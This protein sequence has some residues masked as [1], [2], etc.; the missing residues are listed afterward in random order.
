VSALNV[1]DMQ[2]FFSQYLLV[3]E[4]E[5]TEL[6]AIANNLVTAAARHYA[7]QLY[8]KCEFLLEQIKYYRRTI[9]EGNITGWVPEYVGFVLLHETTACNVHDDAE[10]MEES[11]GYKF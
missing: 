2:T 10:K 1:T 8:G 4:K 3:L 11:V 6:H 5:Y 7:K 9:M